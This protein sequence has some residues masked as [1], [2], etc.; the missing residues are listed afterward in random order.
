MLFEGL[1]AVVRSYR[2]TLQGDRRHLLERFRLVDVARKVVG[3]GSVGMRAW[4]ALFVGRDN[5]DP[6]ILQVK[7]AQAS[8]LEPFLGKSK[9]RNHGH[10]VV[11]GQ[12]L[13][14]AASDQMLGWLRTEGID[15]VERDFFVRQLWDAKGSAL[16]DLMTPRTMRLYAQLCGQTLARAHARS[17]DA[18]AIASYL[19]P[20]D[21]FDRALASFAEAYADQNERDYATL[22]TAADAGRIAIE[23]GL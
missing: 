6:L 11:E 5:D 2:Q 22:K 17:G 18:V 21:A 9:F 8:V 19:G 10:R 14:Q 7:E 13:M 3:V 4:I 12:R 20:S 1:Q 23:T 15:G 16:V